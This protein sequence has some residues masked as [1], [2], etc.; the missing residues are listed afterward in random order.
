VITDD[1]STMVALTV[2]ADAGHSGFP[3]PRQLRKLTREP[4][5]KLTVGK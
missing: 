5:A 2:P 3:N 4:G 1:G